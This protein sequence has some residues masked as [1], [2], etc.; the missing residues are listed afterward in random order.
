MS[1][2]RDSVA[3]VVHEAVRAWARSRGDVSIP[4]WSRA[5]KWMREAT[6]AA[7]AFRL[8]NPGAPASAQHDQWAAEKRA[9]G[10]KRGA[11]KDGVKKTHPLL[12]SYERLPAFERRKDALVGAVIDALTGP[13]A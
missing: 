1:A 3:R 7:I 11:V 4:P 13:L 12:V 9:A 6:V 5:P 10:W 2:K 8:E